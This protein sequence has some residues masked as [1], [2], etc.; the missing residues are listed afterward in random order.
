[1]TP[2][3]VVRL[4]LS[5]KSCMQAVDALE[6]MGLSTRDMENLSFSHAV[7]KVLESCLIALERDGIIP[8]RDGFEFLEMM[9]PFPIADEAKVNRAK[10]I[11]FTKLE[12]HP[13][14]VPK[15]IVDDPERRT[16]EVRYNELV[17]KQNAAPDS[18]TDD[19]MS[20]LA[21]L[22]EEFQR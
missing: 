10:Q 17:F 22:L 21:P 14:Y 11:R 6:K 13:S 4:R 9:R 5:P 7:K 2:G 15:P 18:F 8:T 1:M 3:R 20:E 19:E 16:R 12:Q